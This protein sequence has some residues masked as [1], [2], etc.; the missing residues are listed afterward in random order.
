MRRRLAARAKSV[1]F[2][3]EIEDCQSNV[4]GRHAAEAP[5]H[6][7]EAPDHAAEAPDHAAGSLGTPADAALYARRV[8]EP[9]AL[10]G[11]AAS[12]RAGSDESLVG[13]V[14]RGVLDAELAALVWILVEAR[15]PL[16]VATPEGRAAAGGQLLAAV[17]GS[18]HPDEQLDPL[19]A[20]MG[21]AGAGSL[22]R[23]RRAGG[24]MEA[25]TLGEVRERLGGG[26][27]PLTPDQL[28]F[29]GCV[30]VLGPTGDERRGRL[31]VTAAHYVRPLARDAHG[32]AQRLDPAVLAAWDDRLERW[33]HFAW[34]VIPEV[35]ARLGRKTGDLEA[36][37]HHRR[38]DLAGLAKAGVTGLDEV[39]RLVAGYRVGWGSGHGQAGQVDNTAGHDHASGAPGGDESGHRPH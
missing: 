22:V 36:D 29:L 21:A 7:A 18:I 14:A 6:A 39:R 9:N 27:L 13:L 25:G 19:L 2:G 31:R 26:P 34:G 17:L 11:G 16:V 8:V 32:H 15:I 24:V 30:L 35:A 10:G 37:L 33:E 12:T 3:Y 5:D 28:T 20:P 1:R 23:R 38:D 4:H